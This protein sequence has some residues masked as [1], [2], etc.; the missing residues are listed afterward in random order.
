MLCPRALTCTSFEQPCSSRAAAAALLQAPPGRGV[1]PINVCVVTSPS[2]SMYHR[3]VGRYAA[4]M[5]VLFAYVRD[6]VRKPRML[7]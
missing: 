2:S 5:H 4:C 1:V 7:V 3:L 6:Q